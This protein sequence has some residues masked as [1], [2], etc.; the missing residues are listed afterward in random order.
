MIH[1]SYLDLGTL[2]PPSNPCSMSS[3][4]E[5]WVESSIL[6]PVRFPNSGS[7][8]STGTTGPNL[9]SLIFSSLMRH[10][11]ILGILAF[12]LA[13]RD[14]LSVLLQLQSQGDLWTRVSPATRDFLFSLR[15]NPSRQILFFAPLEL[16]QPAIKTEVPTFII[17]VL[18]FPNL[19][20]SSAVS[21]PQNKFIGNFSL[22]QKRGW[23]DFE[24]LKLWNV[25][26]GN[27]ELFALCSVLLPRIFWDD[28][29]C[30]WTE[31]VRASPCLTDLALLTLY[32]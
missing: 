7:P 4:L 16:K 14:K 25:W 15:F 3:S 13:T 11:L 29:F 9:P 24:A 23:T 18:L 17:T 6:I 32:F 1:S 2:Q 21:E 10:C 26:S 19:T 5:E 12:P 28:C 22:L 30:C 31:L 20:K 27:L 8:E